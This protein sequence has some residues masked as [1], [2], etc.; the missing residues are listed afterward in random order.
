MSIRKQEHVD[1]Q[2]AKRRVVKALPAY[3]IKELKAAYAEYKAAVRPIVA[4]EAKAE[5]AFKSA[6]ARDSARRHKASVEKLW[7]AVC[8]I[9]QELGTVPQKNA[10]RQ[11][12]EALGLQ[13][14]AISHYLKAH[15]TVRSL[16]FTGSLLTE[17]GDDVQ[18][19]FVKVAAGNYVADKVLAWRKQRDEDKRLVDGTSGETPSAEELE[20]AKKRLQVSVSDF[21]AQRKSTAVEHDADWCFE[22]LQTVPKR[23]KR[24]LSALSDDVRKQEIAYRTLL[25]LRHVG[26]DIA[27]G[28]PLVKYV[29]NSPSYLR[30]CDTKAKRLAQEQAKADSKAR[31][32]SKARKTG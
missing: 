20:A 1:K 7:P 14:S 28:I 29:P 10:K 15:E 8:R 11:I 3:V 22:P 4:A 13:K 24:V 5:K 30:D 27:S 31:K 2:S 26:I 12:S 32:R 16:G 19:A 25:W 23:A 18:V 9:V 21:I 6:K 17:A